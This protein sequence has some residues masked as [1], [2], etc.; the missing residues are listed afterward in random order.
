MPFFAGSGTVG[1]VESCGAQ[2]RRFAVRTFCL[3]SVRS[4]VVW[5]HGAVV[6]ED[7]PCHADECPD[8]ECGTTK[9]TALRNNGR[10]GTP[11]YIRSIRCWSCFPGYFLPQPYWHQ[12]RRTY[13]EVYM[14][15][16]LLLFV[17]AAADALVLSVRGSPTAASLCCF[18]L[19]VKFWDFKVANG[20]LGMVHTRSLKVTDDVLCVRYSRHKQQSKLLLAG[21]GLFL[22]LLLGFWMSVRQLLLPRLS[23]SARPVSCLLSSKAAGFCFQAKVL[24]EVFSTVP[25]ASHT[26]SFS[27]PCGASVFDIAQFGAFLRSVR[28]ALGGL[29]VSPLFHCVPYP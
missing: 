8:E 22:L 3:W 29:F 12:W 23:L 20:N 27:T 10:Q 21:V 1:E 17:A 25:S 15:S 4:L 2:G 7:V 18:T 5:E 6:E 13:I 11:I 28:L 9:P 24:G 14:H 26:H 16:L 19:Q